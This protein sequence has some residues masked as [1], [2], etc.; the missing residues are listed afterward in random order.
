MVQSHHPPLEPLQPLTRARRDLYGLLSSNYIQIPNNKVFEMN[1]EPALELLNYPQ[2]GTEKAFNEIQKGL[3]LVKPYGLEKVQPDEAALT[4]LSRD[5]TRLFRGVVRNGILPPYESLYRPERSRR[6]PVQ[7]INRLF[8]EMGIQVPKEWHQPSDYIGVELDFMRLLCERE[9]HFRDNGEQKD[10]R[11]VVE[12]EDSF[13]EEHLAPWV[14]IF[15]TRVLEEAREAY[16]LGIVRLT[17]G[18]FGFDRL[19]VPSLLH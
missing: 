9:I 13:L 6:K 18:L 8:S 11:E 2:K 1:W 7:E 17:L 5:W 16:Y 19:W 12:A 4:K 10:L 14:P 3:N 15:C